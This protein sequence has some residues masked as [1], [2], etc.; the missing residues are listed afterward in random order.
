MVKLLGIVGSPRKGGNTEI[1]VKEALKAAER[2][3]AEVELMHLVDFDIKPCDGCRFCVETR[4]CVV[5][6]DVEKLYQKIVE[7]DGVIVGSPV[8]FQGVN[9]QTKI[10]ID[11]VGYLH[12]VRGRKAFRNKIGGAIVAARRSG[13]VSALCQILMFFISSRMIVATPTVMSLAREKGDAFKDAEATENAIEL[14]KK[15]VEIA[16]ATVSLR[17]V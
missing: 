11:R 15:M 7:A 16:E 17:G 13:L 3:G 14:G 1:L 6:D 2:E 4:S 10:F 9:A 8:Y 12:I 5:K